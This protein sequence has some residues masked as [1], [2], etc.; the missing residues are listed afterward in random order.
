MWEYLEFPPMPKER[1]RILRRPKTIDD[2][3]ELG[4]PPTP[5]KPMPV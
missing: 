2:K 4:K 1:V 5:L 3:L